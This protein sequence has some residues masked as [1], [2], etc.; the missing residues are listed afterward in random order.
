MWQIPSD[1]GQVRHHMFV[2]EAT[3]LA[4]CHRRG[5]KSKLAESI[6]EFLQIFEGNYALISMRITRDVTQGRK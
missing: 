1:E 5:F 3:F 2:G 6:A 4:E